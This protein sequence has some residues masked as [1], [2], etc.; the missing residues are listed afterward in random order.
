MSR[1]LILLLGGARSGKSTYAE[2]LA[3]HFGDRVLY[4]A[5]AQ[6]GDEE[7]PARIAAHRQTRRTI[8]RTIEAPIGVGEAVHAA[9]A[10]G[11]VDAVLLDCLTLLVS[12]VILHGVGEE[13]LDRVDGVAAQ[14][15]V[16]V[17]LNGLL[18]VFRAADVPWIVVS[19][20]V[21]FGL[22]PPYR[23]GRVY[24]DLLGWA[25]QRMAAEANQVYLMIAGLPLNIKNTNV[26]TVGSLD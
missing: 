16:E 20:E 11:A 3:G 24:R 5:T 4:V 7:M 26:P 25:N 23:L 9:L 18:D 10:S 6:A 1:Q 12:N 2:K 17:E 13:D 22:V 15:Q 14:L 21:G 8:W 19:N